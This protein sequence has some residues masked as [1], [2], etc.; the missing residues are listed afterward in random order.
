MHPMALHAPEIV[1]EPARKTQEPRTPLSHFLSLNT[2]LTSVRLDLLLRSLGTL[3]A[4]L[5]STLGVLGSELS[6]LSLLSSGSSLLLLLALLD[7]L[8]SGGGTS[9]GSDGSTL[10]NH[11]EGGTDDGSLGLDGS[12]GSLLGNLLEGC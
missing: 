7:G 12:A 6:L 1:E 4:N 5:S 10:L 11:I 9:L 3:L 2:S 8:G